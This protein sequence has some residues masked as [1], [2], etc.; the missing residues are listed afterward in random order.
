MKNADSRAHG[1]D[2]PWNIAQICSYLLA[3]FNLAVFIMCATVLCKSK[4][5]STIALIVLYSGFTIALAI[6]AAR[7]TLS[8]P[9]D[10]T[11]TLE[12]THKWQLENSVQNDRRVNF[13]KSKYS[14]YCDLCQ[15]HV[16][17]GTKHCRQCNRCTQGFDHHC[18]WIN[19]DIGKSNYRDFVLLLLA[20]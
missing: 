11:I 5:N 17:P 3:L 4:P 18:E 7:T 19:N 12:R 1:F 15:T 8:D 6:Y 2:C 14:Y 20:L 13:D 16:L 9:T 10:P